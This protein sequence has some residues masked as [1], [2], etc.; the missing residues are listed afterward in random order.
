VRRIL[1][2]IT[3]LEIGGTPTVVRELAVRLHQPPEICV[4]VA[5]LARRGPVA[6]Q[7][8]ARGITVHALDASGTKDLGLFNRFVKLLRSGQYDTVFSFL[9][10]ANLVAAAASLRTRGVRFIQSIQTTQ[11]NPRWHWQ[12]QRFIHP[13]AG[14][15]VV[16]SASVARC[17]EE[18]SHVSAGKIVI[19]PNAIDPG[20]FADLAAR[21]TFTSARP[22]RVGFIGRLDSVK[23]IPDLIRATS[24]LGDAAHLH[25]YGAGAQR[26]QLEQLVRTSQLESRV[27]F[28]G[29]TPRPHDALA[30]MDVLVLPS[31]AEGFGL[32][33]IEAMAAGVPVVATRAPGIRDVVRHGTTGLLVPI[34]SPEKLAE[35]ITS[36]ANNSALRRKLIVLGKEHVHRRFTW[37]RTLPMYKKLL[38]LP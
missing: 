9:L 23:R 5:C 22:V 4:D 19:I 8:E 26:G 3:D 38:L 30:K 32:V 15:I 10:H 1:L 25:L 21:D 33:L 28:H 36:A 18:R 27:T 35:A 31:E 7:L 12:V 17:A 34:G 37:E 29:A 11:A 24:I 16:P 13:A 14:E 6:D 20:E 2:L